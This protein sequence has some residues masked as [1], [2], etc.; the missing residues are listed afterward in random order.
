[1]GN[2]PK[3]KQ[4]VLDL[5]TV[6]NQ[7]YEGEIYSFRF[8]PPE[9]L[10]NEPRELRLYADPER[11]E[12]DIFSLAYLILFSILERVE[13]FDCPSYVTKFI[14]NTNYLGTYSLVGVK[15][16]LSS[17]SHFKCLL[18][19]KKQV[20]ICF[21]DTL[22]VQ[23]IRQKILAKNIPD[24][25]IEVA[26][27]KNRKFLQI[28]YSGKPVID[29]NSSGVKMTFWAEN[30]EEL[31]AHLALFIELA[32]FIEREIFFAY[33]S[34]ITLTDFQPFI[35]LSAPKLFVRTLSD[36]LRAISEWIKTKGT[37][38]EQF[39][40]TVRSIFY[41]QKDGDNCYSLNKGYLDDHIEYI[42]YLT[43]TNSLSVKFKLFFDFWSIKH[44]IEERG[45]SIVES[46]S[47]VEDHIFVKA[48]GGSRSLTKRFTIRE[49][50]IMRGDHCILIFSNENI[51]TIP[52]NEDTSALELF[53]Q[54]YYRR[55]FIS[56][57]L[58]SVNLP[59]DLLDY[60]KVV[61]K[62][63]QKLF[64]LYTFFIQDELVR[65][66]AQAVKAIIDAGLD[67]GFPPPPAPAA[68][69]FWKI[70]NDLN[71][72]DYFEKF[73]ALLLIV[74]ELVEK[75]KPRISSYSQENK[76]LANELYVDLLKII[77]AS[78]AFVNGYKPQQM[79]V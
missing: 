26:S 19:S 76:K 78:T 79:V 66:H 1:V 8:F 35:E 34:S 55:M 18:L 25:K 2:L 71:E 65:E 44:L 12:F 3:L 56:G 13:L 51:L 42:I 77:G 6:L 17:F 10:K 72:S 5:L 15:K 46:K 74:Q 48:G 33:N 9:P 24:L 61:I 70:L 32:T 16:Y 53:D 54:V 45:L 43:R 14:N 60:E 28:W 63:M 52:L 30:S 64:S 67:E 36:N 4:A 57:W 11:K 39:K 58:D 69:W 21:T 68:E 29:F 62:N 31:S 40:E 75:S 7:K 23:Q 47:K 73:H 38:P 49:K 27:D 37:L 22:D 41:H 50:R 20:I 59:C